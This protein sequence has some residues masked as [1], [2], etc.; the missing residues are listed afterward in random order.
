MHKIFAANLSKV[1]IDTETQA[2]PK[3]NAPAI[4]SHLFLLVNNKKYTKKMTK[5]GHFS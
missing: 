1:P 3:E 4:I 5:I 2:R